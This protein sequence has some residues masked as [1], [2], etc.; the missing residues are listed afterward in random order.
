MHT[1]TPTAYRTTVTNVMVVTAVTPVIELMNR[2]ARQGK[3]GFSAQFRSCQQ[4]TSSG[5]EVTDEL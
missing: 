2:L 5:R 3:A 4:R 1:V